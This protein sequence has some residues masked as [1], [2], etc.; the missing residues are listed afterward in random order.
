MDSL[1]TIQLMVASSQ[2]TGMH[3]CAIHF[4]H[5]HTIQFARFYCL[6]EPR[7]SRAVP[8]EKLSPG[9]QIDVET[10]SHHYHIECLGGNAIRI[11]GHPEYCPMPVV[12][13]PRFH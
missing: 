3:V 11:H 2:L 6:E 12:A 8:E 10:K 1:V 4:V 7:Q 9:S 13:I 5:H